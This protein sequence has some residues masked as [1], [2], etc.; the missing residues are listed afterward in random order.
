MSVPPG[1]FLDDGY[2]EL[3]DPDDDD[4]NELWMTAFDESRC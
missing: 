4:S 3:E 1:V 2:W